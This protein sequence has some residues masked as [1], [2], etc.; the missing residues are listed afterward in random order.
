MGVTALLV[1]IATSKVI[2]KLSPERSTTGASKV[3]SVA[4]L[5]AMMLLFLTKDRMGW[6]HWITSPSAIIYSNGTVLALAVAAG[7][8]YHL[9]NRPRWRRVGGSVVLGLLAMAALF[10]PALQPIFRPAVGG[11]SWASGGVCLQSTPHNCSAAAGATLL[12][13][14]GIDVTEKQMVDWCRCARHPFLRL[15]DCHKGTE[16]HPVAISCRSAD[17]EGAWSWWWDCRFTV[18]ILSITTSMGGHPDFAIRSSC[19]ELSPTEWLISATLRLAGK[20]GVKRIFRFCIVVKLSRLMKFHH[21]KTHRAER[22]GRH[23]VREQLASP[24]AF[25]RW[26]MQKT[27]VLSRQQILYRKKLATDFTDEHGSMT[28]LNPCSSVPSV[29]SNSTLAI[30]GLNGFSRC[31]PRVLNALE[32]AKHRSLRSGTNHSECLTLVA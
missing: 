9:P 12:K 11:N 25:K 17:S 5:S 8:I 28:I 20:P 22:K 13:A 21:G 19:L 29:G 14:R 23:G 32:V 2:G 26:P 24:S 1:A 6:A 15:K 31:L 27:K 16:Y 10:Q 3:V 30:G 18:R 4:V 7:G